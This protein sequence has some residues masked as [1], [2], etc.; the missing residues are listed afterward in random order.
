MFK[1]FKRTRAIVP[2]IVVTGKIK[3]NKETNTYGFWPNYTKSN[4]L[5]QQYDLHLAKSPCKYPNITIIAVINLET[6]E[7]IEFSNGVDGLILKLAK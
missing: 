1:L 5:K 4:E 6:N 7:V 3:H 2:V